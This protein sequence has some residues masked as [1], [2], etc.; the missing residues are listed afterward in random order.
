MPLRPNEQELE[1][2]RKKHRLNF[3][4][5]LSRLYSERLQSL[6]LE[7]SVIPAQTLVGMTAKASLVSAI[8]E[9]GCHNNYFDE[10]AL[11]LSNDARLLGTG[12][13]MK[14]ARMRRATRPLSHAEAYHAVAA[15]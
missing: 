2:L 13:A 11:S 3:L 10:L 9:R 12:C 8:H 1:R 6:A 4:E 14:P 15:E 5:R 7:I